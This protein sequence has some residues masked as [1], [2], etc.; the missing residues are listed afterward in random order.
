MANSH[1]L[2]KREEKIPP[3]LNHIYGQS[4]V[5]GALLGVASIVIVLSTP[6]NRWIV[7]LCTALATFAVILTAFAGLNI[8]AQIWPHNLLHLITRGIKTL[9]R[10]KERG[11][12]ASIIKVLKVLEDMMPEPKCSKHADRIKQSFQS[13]EKFIKKNTDCAWLLPPASNDILQIDAHK[14]NHIKS[15]F[16]EWS[17]LV[18]GNTQIG[19]RGLLKDTNYVF[20][21][22]DLTD[23]AKWDETI[24]V[25]LQPMLEPLGERTKSNLLLAHR[26]VI[27]NWQEMEQNSAT[28]TDFLKKIWT[29]YFSQFV[30]ST[31]DH[32]R[33][34]FID[35]NALS[36]SLADYDKTAD[37]YDVALFSFSR[38]VREYAEKGNILPSPEEANESNEYAALEYSK[39]DVPDMLHLFFVQGTAARGN[40]NQS[41]DSMIRE[42]RKNIREIYD[43][44][45]SLDSIDAKVKSHLG[46]DY[47]EF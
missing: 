33:I 46:I 24:L 29:P 17:W 6:A 22:W 35:S 47:A 42:T 19:I 4:S 12:P 34:K 15:Q 45:R 26:I 37:F 20:I 41:G 11:K 25:N 27:V 38:K 13:F 9:S 8:F 31:N 5:V 7:A 39:R 3:W 44:L 43:V 14:K 1:S 2:N 18:A 10:T 28:S 32:Y 16:L 40:G 30:S 23:P 21:T 36:A